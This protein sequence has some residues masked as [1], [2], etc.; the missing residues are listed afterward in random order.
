MVHTTNGPQTLEGPAPTRDEVVAFL[1]GLR[2]EHTAGGEPFADSISNR[3]PNMNREL[4]DCCPRFGRGMRSR[5]R[6]ANTGHRGF[7]R[8]IDPVWLKACVVAVLLGLGVSVDCR[9][10][11][12]DLIIETNCN[13]NVG[14]GFRN[15]YGSA[16]HEQAWA[17]LRRLRQ[18]DRAVS[19]RAFLGSK[20]RRIR[21]VSLFET[22]AAEAAD[23]IRGVLSSVII[24]PGKR[25]GP[26]PEGLLWSESTPVKV[27]A[28]L[29]YDNGR[30]GLFE[31]DGTH[32]FFEDSDGTY[33]WHRW[34]SSFP[35][36][37]V[38][39]DDR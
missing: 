33:W 9:G 38:A 6:Q 26:T 12:S 37:A 24:E 7:S 16:T 15:L 4:R 19:V 29:E 1:P 32:L 14:A 21:I 11:E 20:L 39:E 5:S 3:T 27:R 34:D 17:K 36:R 30:V 10:A 28:L 18:S 31:T 13:W 25:G 8:F 23:L 2:R 35:R 22:S